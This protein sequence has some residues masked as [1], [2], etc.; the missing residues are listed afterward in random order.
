MQALL[1]AQE[2]PAYPGE[3]VAVVSDRRDARALARGTA[4]GV[5]AD[6]VVM[7][8]F[9]DRGAWDR[10]LGDTVAAHRPD[11]VVLAGFM[12]I[13]APDFLQRFPGRVINTHP[14]L[15]PDFPGAHAV[16]DALQ[17]GVPVTGASV[18]W[19]DE[20]IDTGQVIT[21]AEVPLFAGDDEATLHERIK[22][23]ERQMLV[24]VVAQLVAA[25]HPSVPGA[26]A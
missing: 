16:R 10:A 6:A 20:G 4:H 23:V 12:K 24:R 2:D 1:D 5:P 22:I 17:A 7:G 3:V 15:L 14:G 11:L 21:Q 8:D 26:S 18:I 25:Q 13:L 19:V 9:P